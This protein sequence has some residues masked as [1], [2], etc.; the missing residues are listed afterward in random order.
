MDWKRA[1]TYLDGLTREDIMGMTDEEARAAQRLFERLPFNKIGVFEPYPYQRQFYKAG[2]TTQR[3][4]LMAA[5][6][7]GKSFGMAME[8]SY[9]LTGL[10]PADWEG[11]KFI[12]LE[13]VDAEGRP[14]PH[15]LVVW[16]V[17]ITGDSTRKVLQKELFGTIMAKDEKNLGTGAI[18]RDCIDFE[19]L[20]RDGNIIRVAKI[21]HHNP[22]GEFDGYSTLEFRS[23][24]QGEHTLMG[25]TVDFIWLDE[26]DPYCSQEIYSQCVTRTATTKGQVVITA[27]PENGLTAMITQFIEDKTGLLY[28]QNATWDDAPHLTEEVKRELLASIPPW[29]QEMRA[30]GLPVQGSGAIF[31]VAD[32][33]IT[34]DPITPMPHWPILAAVDFAKTRDPSIIMFI[35]KD[36]EGRYIV[37]DEVY[38]DDDRSVHNMAKHIT[39]THTPNIPVIIPHDGNGTVEGLGNQTRGTILRDLGCNVIMD[40]FSNPEFIQN[41]ITSVHKKNMGKEGGLYWMDYGFK[42]GFIKVA[43]NCKNFFRQKQSYFWVTRG[44]KTVP[45]DGGDDTIDASRYGLLSIDRYGVPFGQCQK[46]GDDYN[47]GF[48]SEPSGITFTY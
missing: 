10:Y 37:Y 26:E 17:G 34:I 47:N 15:D 46:G 39:S 42:E 21:K 28:Y 4:F 8:V 40:V 41:T 24:Q 19:L 7:I 32:S 27:T 13:M 3:R 20:E 36:D 30:R 14:N 35:T 33:A 6:R 18:P 9:H 23:T 45:K 16:A 44:G 31:Q 5:N 38:L 1:K 12:K 48:D 11:K 29:Q 2:T 22:E 25:S 43:A